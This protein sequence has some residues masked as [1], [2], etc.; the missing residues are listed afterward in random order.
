MAISRLFYL[1]AWLLLTQHTFAIPNPQPLPTPAPIKPRSD[2]CAFDF[3]TPDPNPTL[4]P[5]GVQYAQV[6][7]QWCTDISMSAS[8]K[9]QLLENP[10]TAIATLSALYAAAHPTIAASPDSC[11]MSDEKILEDPIAQAAMEKMKSNALL[12]TG[13]D[14]AYG[15]IGSVYASAIQEASSKS[16]VPVDMITNIIQ[17]ESKGDPIIFQ[18]LTQLDYLAWGYMVTWYPQLGLT[19]KYKPRDNIVAS[20]MYLQNLVHQGACSSLEI[21]YSNCYQK[22]CSQQLQPPG[23]PIAG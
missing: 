13:G 5:P 16:T 6:M 7:S 14:L 18:G 1:S 12:G 20:A 15:D 3:G 10:A 11:I 19:N 21:C 4:A 8:Y 23:A 2:S 9:D 17:I 22:G